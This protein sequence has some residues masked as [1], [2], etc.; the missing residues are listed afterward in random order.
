M[1][2]FNLVILIAELMKLMSY[3]K[4]D[5]KYLI[6]HDLIINFHYNNNNEPIF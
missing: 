6:M 5:S 2:I 1:R 4:S 3:V